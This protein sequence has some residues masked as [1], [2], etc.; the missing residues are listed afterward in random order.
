MIGPGSVVG[1]VRSVI[2]LCSNLSESSNSIDTIQS[3]PDKNPDLFGPRL[4]ISLL[5]IVGNPE[6][7]CRALTVEPLASGDRANW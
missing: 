3:I 6:S 4:T 7:S 1:I 2:Q 5:I